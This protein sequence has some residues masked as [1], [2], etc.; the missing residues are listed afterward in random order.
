[1]EKQCVDVFGLSLLILVFGLFTP[2]DVLAEQNA[3]ARIEKL[4]QQLKVLQEELAALKAKEAEEA[5]KPTPAVDEKQ[6]ETM[7][8]KILAGRP[9]P[10]L[11]PTD[12]RMFWK[13][14]L[15]FET[16]NK[17]FKFKFGGR[18]MY[19]FGWISEDDDLKADLGDDQHDSTETR[20]ARLYLSGLIYDNIDFKLQFDF[21]GGDADLKDAYIG[22]EDFPIGKIRAGHFKEPFGL[23]ELTSSKYITFMERSLPTEAFAPS[24][25]AGVMLFDSVFDDRMTWAAGIFRNTDD[26]GDD[27]DDDD[28]GYGATARVTGV[29]IYEDL[30]ASLLHVGASYSSRDTAYNSSV[31]KDGARFRSRPEAH[32]FDR[33]VDTGNFASDHMDLYGLEGAW[34]SGPLSIQGEYIFAE[35]DASSDV[36]F[37]GYYVQASYFLTG[38]HRKYKP[39]SGT[40]S[41]VKPKKNFGSDGGWGAWE[42]AARYSAVDLDDSSISGGKLDNITAGLNWHLNPNTRL[43]W[44][45]VHADKDDIGDADMFLMRLQIDF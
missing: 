14:G 18:L 17:D 45:Y 32:L 40:F 7:V 43:M 15:R 8:D 10:E 27:K 21:A 20:R 22:L 26:Y 16:P 39:S 19:D 3:D 41:R 1:M 35:A 38:E 5:K 33:F 37:D 42:V 6:V 25:N 2:A 44:N 23:E 36:S 31:G 13:D 34:V 4:E 11:G 29:P 24:R 28:G 12:F 30:G 9:R